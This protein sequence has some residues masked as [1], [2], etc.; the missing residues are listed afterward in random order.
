MNGETDIS[1]SFQPVPFFD[2]RQGS[3]EDLDDLLSDSIRD[4]ISDLALIN[5]A[6]I[7]N[8]EATQD[9]LLR[10]QIQ[11]SNVL[12]KLPYGNILFDK[13]DPFLKQWDYT[14]QIGDDVRISNAVNFPTQGLRR[15]AQQSQLSN[16]FIRTVNGSTGLTGGT[17]KITSTYRIM[18]Q[19][20]DNSITI[21]IGTLVGGILYPF[22]ISFLLPIFVITLVKEKEERILI[23]MRMNG[24]KS[25]AYYLTH[26]THFYT[27]Q[28]ITCN[29]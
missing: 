1:F 10:F 20:F 19:L 17:A 23:M 8:D 29:V 22:G 18:P 2:K 12:T 5:K 25:F 7:F 6:I 24:L 16:S 21:P 13:I 27:L 3:I 15:L 14:L 28:V 11:I 26:Y 4:V 9:Q